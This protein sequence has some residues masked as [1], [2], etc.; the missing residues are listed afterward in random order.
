MKHFAFAAVAALIVMSAPARAADVS[1]KLSSDTQNAIVQLPAVLDQC[2]AGL[3]MRGD[4]SV[5]KSI[6]AFLVGMGNEVKAEAA[7]ADKAAAD[8]AAADKAAAAAPPVPAAPVPFVTSP[9]IPV[10]PTQ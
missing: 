5:C 7:A 10:A 6:S 2:V 9:A 1:V 8:K 4:A 3:T